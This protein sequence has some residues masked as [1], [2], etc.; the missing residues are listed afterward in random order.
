L[1]SDAENSDSIS[2]RALSRSRE[3]TRRIRY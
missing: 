2:L 3:H 1:P